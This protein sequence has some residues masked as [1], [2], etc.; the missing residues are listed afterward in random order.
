MV[1]MLDF[2]GLFWDVNDEVSFGGFKVVDDV[3]SE[4]FEIVEGGGV[5]ESFES[6]VGNDFDDFGY[7][8]IWFGQQVWVF[9]NGIDDFFG[10][11]NGYSFGFGGV[12]FDEDF[13]DFEFDLVMFLGI[14]FEVVEIDVDWQF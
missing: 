10:G 1:D 13:G 7:E 9:E 4:L 6:I 11:I 12:V 8:G 5:V 14:F 3:L 2:W